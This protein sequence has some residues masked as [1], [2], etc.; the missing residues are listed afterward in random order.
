MCLWKQFLI[1][2][3]ILEKSGTGSSILSSFSKTFF[4]D[5]KFDLTCGILLYENLEV[6]PNLILT[7]S[8]GLH[9]RLH[10]IVPED[11]L[12]VAGSHDDNVRACQVR[13]TES[14]SHWPH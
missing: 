12:P 6:P 5:L 2:F 9:N 4:G 11:R 10:I 13:V 8:A 1:L 3:K 7:H 14:H